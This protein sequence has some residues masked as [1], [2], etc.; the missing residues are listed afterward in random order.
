MYRQ[1]IFRSN[2]EPGEL[3]QLVSGLHS[4]NPG[5]LGSLM[6]RGSG[7]GSGGSIGKMALGRST[8]ARE[9]ERIGAV[10]SEKM[11]GLEHRIRVLTRL[12]DV[13]LA[14]SKGGR[15]EMWDRF[16]GALAL[17]DRG[18]C[19]LD[20]TALRPARRQHDLLRA[21]DGGGARPNRR[22]PCCR[23]QVSLRPLP[24]PAGGLEPPTPSLQVKC[25]TS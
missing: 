19:L 7:G 1:R 25:S 18:Q 22:F 11:S 20:V 23:D 13:L 8:T 5:M 17:P 15:Q 9:R 16:S 10:V 12:R 2:H 14:E 21:Y 3:A 6:G 24:E 4:Q